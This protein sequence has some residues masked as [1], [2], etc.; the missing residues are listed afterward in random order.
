MRH[1]AFLFIFIFFSQ[2]CLSEKYQVLEINEGNYIVV[3]KKRHVKEKDFFDDN[4]KLMLT[5]NQVVAV[6]NVRTKRRS[7]IIGKNY[8][9]KGRKTL[10]DYLFPKKE[11]A[12]RGSLGSIKEFIGEELFWVDSLAIQTKLPPLAER[13]FVLEIMLPEGQIAER[14]LK[15]EKKGTRICFD[16]KDIWGDSI[17]SPIIVNLK[18]GT[19]DKY[20]SEGTYEII[21]S[22]IKLTPLKNTKKDEED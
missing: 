9:D 10:S 22:G 5:A 7:V 6:R 12:V 18:V 15:T 21:C 17:P 14:F 2:M 4:D 19:F 1:L 16:S 3:N 11:G 20:T 13:K 8:L